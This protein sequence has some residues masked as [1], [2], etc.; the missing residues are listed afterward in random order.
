V[1]YHT[2]P[3]TLDCAGVGERKQAVPSRRE[4]PEDLRVPGM[5]R[6]PSSGPHDSPDPKFNNEM[7]AKFMNVVNE[8]RQIPPP[9]ALSMVRSN[10]IA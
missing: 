2:V 7:L 1:R 9:S 6:E 5:S 10:R 4:A 3:R 8:E